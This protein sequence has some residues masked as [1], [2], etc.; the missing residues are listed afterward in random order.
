MTDRSASSLDSV[1]L[2][3][4]DDPRPPELID[5]VENDDATVK[6]PFFVSGV[7]GKAVMLGAYENGQIGYF[8][9][10]VD[11]SVQRVGADPSSGQYRNFAS[12]TVTKTADG[13]VIFAIAMNLSPSP[14]GCTSTGVVTLETSANDKSQSFEMSPPVDMWWTIDGELHAVLWPSRCDG[15]VSR[16]T[17]PAAE[18]RL[19]DSR[20]IKVSDVPVL[21]RRPAFVGEWSNFHTNLTIR[22]DGSATV[23]GRWDECAADKPCYLEYTMQSHLTADKKTFIAVVSGYRL[24]VYDRSGQVVPMSSPAWGASGPPKD[25]VGII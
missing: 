2:F 22:S 13:L 20:W 9:Y 7:E 15:N 6:Y 25:I 23:L 16:E 12:G 24:V 1:L 18:W 8:A 19:S 14:G 11:G 4:L 10:S 21:A 3:D 5:E 17:A